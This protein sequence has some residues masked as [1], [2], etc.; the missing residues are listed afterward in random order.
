MLVAPS[1]HKMLKAT[2][3]YQG[4]GWEGTGTDGDMGTAGLRGRGGNR[5]QDRPGQG[6]AGLRGQRDGRT[7]FQRGKRDSQKA[8]RLRAS[9]QD[10]Q[11]PVAIA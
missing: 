9:P 1:T 3:H 2:D 8:W 11:D 10:V 7:Q 4:V 6:D 5:S